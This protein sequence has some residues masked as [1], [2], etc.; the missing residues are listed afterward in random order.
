MTFK[1]VFLLILDSL[2]VG[3]T[4]DAINYNS[5]GANTLKHVNE[6]K[7]LFVP[8]LEKIGFM[9][10]IN[11]E[12][13]NEVDAYYTIA[14]PINKGIDSLS[15]HYEIMGVKN[16]IPFETFSNAFDTNLLEKIASITGRRIIG[17]VCCTNDKII[18]DLG[19]NEKAFASLIIYTS[20][21]SNMQI[22]AHE[23]AIPMSTLYD[24][25]DKIKEFLDRN[26][27]NVSRVII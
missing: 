25:A 24:Y 3:E 7:T 22:A 16:E 5:V 18:K 12:E 2:G 10:T 14:H 17:N 6:N 23:D 27:L 9:N 4:T 13:N 21:D 8:N 11:L 26:K 15:G 19:D 1:R 20:G